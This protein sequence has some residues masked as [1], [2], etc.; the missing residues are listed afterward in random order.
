MTTPLL[1]SLLILTLILFLTV[2]LS[3]AWSMNRRQRGSTSRFLPFLR[4]WA[5][6]NG[7]KLLSMAGLVIVFSLALILQDY[8][9]VLPNSLKLIRVPFMVRWGLGMA[10][11]MVLCVI[12]DLFMSRR[13]YQRATKVHFYR[14]WLKRSGMRFCVM[15]VV[16]ALMLGGIWGVRQYKLLQQQSLASRYLTS[17]VRYFRQQKFREATLELRNAIKE[18][19]N[20]YEAL[21]WLARCHWQL[22]NLTEARR[23]YKESARIEPKLYLAHLELGRLAFA[24]GLKEEAVTKASQ[25][26]L[27]AQQAPEPRLLLAGIYRSTGGVEPA[28]EQYRAILATNSANREVRNLLVGM[29]LNSHSFAD[30]GREAENGLRVNPRDTDLMAALAT[31]RDGEG[32]RGEAETMLKEATRQDTISPLPLVALGELYVRH[33]EYLPALQCYEEAL[34]R[35]PNN[36]TII[37]NTALLHAEHGYDLT[38]AAELASRIYSRYPRE[39]AVQDTM[40]WVLFKQGKLTQAI[41]LLRLAASGQPANPAHHYHYGAALLKAGQSLTGRAEVEKALKISPDFDGVS[42]ARRLLGG[43]VTGGSGARHGVSLRN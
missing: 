41:L 24:M 2:D 39:P 31:A 37:N 25:A 35:S 18:N 38:R 26:L 23:E 20:D 16:G 19:P 11:I 15:G 27:L 34:K 9:L 36:K 12:F 43:A 13:A 1:W 8:T 5:A 17:A 7:I 4:R 21:L 10:L 28:A 29:L 6:M 22:G 40:G 3:F 33:R 14:W 30:A 42:E 32:R